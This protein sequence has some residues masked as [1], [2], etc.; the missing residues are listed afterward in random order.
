MTFSQIG[1]IQHGKTDHH[2]LGFRDID[3][4]ISSNIMGTRFVISYRQN[5]AAKK[6]PVI[7]SHKRASFSGSSHVYIEE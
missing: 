4:C 2:D 3:C 1:S 7:F 6:K 5:P